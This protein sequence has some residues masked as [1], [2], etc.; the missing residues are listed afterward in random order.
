MAFSVED[1]HDLVTI[2]EQRP[3]WRAE[4][5]RLVLTE[6]ILSL[7]QLMRELAERVDQL[8][9]AQRV[10]TER[11]DRLAERF[12][13][14]ADAL[15]M[16]TERVDRLAEGQRVLTER[17]DRLTERVD[18]LAERLDRLTERVDRLTERVDGLAERMGQLVEALVALT[19]NVER[20]AQIQADMLTDV[21]KL[22]GS[23]MERRYRERPF[24]YFARIVRGAHTMTG[25][26]LIAFLGHA[27]ERGHISA[28]EEDEILLADAVVRGRRR[29]DG[30]EVYLVVEVSWGVGVDDVRRASERAATLAKTG[31][32]SIPVVAGDRVTADARLMAED[33]KVWQVTD[34][35]VV[36]PPG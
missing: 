1:F 3:E 24:A 31:V 12:D 36:A 9:E 18:A 15:R 33:Q 20:L 10:L 4:L 35:Q 2:L 16:L 19:E 32:A 11:V 13:Q 25:D 28:D 8:A 23:D 22:K 26:E 34:G 6:D 7:P 21:A 30:A 27:V 14:L 5:R 17:L 29:E